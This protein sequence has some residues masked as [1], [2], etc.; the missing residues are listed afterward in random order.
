MPGPIWG[1]S[2]LNRTFKTNDMTKEQIAFVEGHKEHFDLTIN[3][4]QNYQRSHDIA[5]QVVVIAEEVTGKP[6]DQCSGCMREA[7]QAVWNEYQLTLNKNEQHTK[8]KKA[9]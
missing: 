4:G 3:H 6:V 1:H 2:L 8:T 7:Y 9:E 5:K